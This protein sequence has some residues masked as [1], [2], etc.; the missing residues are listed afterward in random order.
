M[1]K[2][3]TQQPEGSA[4]GV[5]SSSGELLFETLLKEFI[6]KEENTDAGR[7]FHQSSPERLR[8]L[9]ANHKTL[10]DKHHQQHR[11]L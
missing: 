4:K 10:R 7:E 6:G 9:S 1:S 2:P 5:F 3:Q 11:S 8:K